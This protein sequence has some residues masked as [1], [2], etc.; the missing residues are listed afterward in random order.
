MAGKIIKNAIVA[1][2]L[3]V[4]CATYLMVQ[5]TFLQ[6]TKYTIKNAKLPSE[7]DGYT[8]AQISDFHSTNSNRLRKSTI[9]GIKNQKVDMIVI[10][11]DFVD[12]RHDNLSDSL[13]FAKELTSIAPTFFILGNHE[14]YLDNS[15]E[16]ITKLKEVGVTVL[17]NET[18][19]V[20]LNGACINLVGITDP[21][22]NK[23][24]KIEENIVQFLE[25]AS[26]DDS[27]YTILLSH[28]P[29]VCHL[30]ENANIDLTISGHA[31]G[32]QV[33]IPFVGG[34]IS[35][36]EG[37]WPKYTEGVHKINDMHLVISRGIG[38]SSF[39]FRINN[40]PELVFIELK[41]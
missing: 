11:G 10:T 36:G 3:S 5:N 32:G 20:S 30:Y 39:P 2:V 8:I 28:R 40:R 38:S 34:V 4:G 1:K 27:N 15:D 7:F 13:D 33:R 9:E 37:F 23:D 24:K 18:H 16:F 12:E 31:H 41:Q 29:E 22:S 19:I 21:A 17:Q 26:Y 25:D 14:V 35:P 6:T